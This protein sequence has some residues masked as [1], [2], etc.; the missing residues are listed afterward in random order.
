MSDASLH[1]RVV[2]FE[3][4]ER[5][6][7]AGA[8]LA[9]QWGAGKCGES[10]AARALNLGHYVALRSHDLTDLQYRLAAHGLSSLGRSEGQA[11]A[12]VSAVLTVR[13]GRPCW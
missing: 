4:F 11:Q 3:R 8:K 6:I 10:A 5:K 2:E 9:K 12:S 13:C 1:A 7:A